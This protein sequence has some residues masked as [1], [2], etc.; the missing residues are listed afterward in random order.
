MTSPPSDGGPVRATMLGS[1]G[2]RATRLGLGLAA[3]G[4]PAYITMG[5]G[6]DLGPDRAT[7]TM[8]RRCHEV[9]DAARALGIGYI[10]AARSYGR[11]EEFLS[12]W[13]EDRAVPV[14]S[15]SVGS[16]WGY[17]YV[18]DW[19]LDASVH[20][21]KDHSLAM[22][23]AQ[24]PESQALLGAHL[25]LYQVH[26]A[27]LES[28][29][30]DDVA[31]LGALGE[32]RDSGT[33]VGLSVSGPRQADVIMRALDVVVS[34]KP[35]FATVQATWNLLETS[36]GGALAEA[37][38]RGVGVLVKEALANGRLT[39]R[40]VPA[41]SPAFPASGASGAPSSSSA[42]S[43]SSATGPTAEGLARWARRRG[44]SLDRLALA[45]A[46]AQPWADVVLSGAVTVAQLRANVDAVAIGLDGDEGDEAMSFAEEPER[47]WEGRALLPWC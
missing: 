28:G 46:A 24:L 4:R 21:T 35:L 10:D 45:A 7:D 8:R 25:R 23:R 15:V 18:G 42:L 36:A 27:T 44:T 22:L 16:K 37:H 3:L 1:S 20:E 26:S 34:G 12:T 31:V 2:V 39:D 43:S 33:A 6:D 13:L 41:L 38:A 30:L 40:A 14:G 5:R 32:L 47:Y 19:R 11:A 29:V 9:L 17:R